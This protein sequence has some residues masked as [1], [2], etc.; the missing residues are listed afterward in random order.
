MAAIRRREAALLAVVALIAVYFMIWP[1]WRAWFPLDIGP[2][3]GWNA[4][5][6]DLA[7]G[8]GLYP[9]T[10]ALVV[11]NYPPLSFYFIA[12]L[13]KLFGDPLYV[14]R[15]VSIL[16]TLGIGIEVGVV[17][18]QLGGSRFASVFA[19]LWV[20]AIL[21]RSFN[22]YVGRD[23]PQ[24]L[25]E[26]V[27]ML[28][29][30][31]FLRNSSRGFSA[32]LPL[33]L[34]VLAGFVKHNVV[35]VPLTAVIWLCWHDGRKAVR[36]LLIVAIAIAA[37]L[38]LCGLMYP[39]FFANML[40]PRAY[41]IKRVVLALGRLQW[42]APALAI[43]LMWAWR[44]GTKMSARFTMLFVGV[45]LLMYL[46]QWTGDS[47]MDNAQFDLVIATAVGIGLAYNYAASLPFASRLGVIRTRTAIVA[48]LATRLLATGRIEPALILFDAD[49]RAQ[50]SE[51]AAIVHAEA[52]KVARI[53]GTVFC[54]SH[55]ICRMAGKPFEVDDFKT[56]QL[57]NTGQLTPAQL[58]ALFQRKGVT[59]VAAD[60]ATRAESLS[61]DIF[62]KP[63]PPVAARN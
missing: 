26:F 25:A 29:L 33:L 52:A 55:I 7:F 40:S 18:R 59:I 38:L 56:E 21:A 23:D 19:G 41:S 3:D 1:V 58:A 51:H 6:Q 48:I 27:M 44:E 11:N 8:P 54:E 53:P 57:V 45:G 4:Y 35:A 43:S 32:T 42:V 39:T 46:V 22:F 61:R 24:L 47:V 63:N 62:G 5:F 15:A 31:W 50:F 12:A 28:G 34:M 2:T 14:G 10:D 20:I 37:G 36:P 49:Y 17:V 30:I 60:P 16:A 13:A 9:P